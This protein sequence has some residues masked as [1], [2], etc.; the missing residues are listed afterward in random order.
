MSKEPAISFVFDQG[1]SVSPPYLGGAGRSWLLLSW[2]LE[3]DTRWL[4][5]PQLKT[6]SLLN[7]PKAVLQKLAAL[8][9]LNPSAPRN[10]RNFV[11]HTLSPV[12]A[13]AAKESSKPR[14]GNLRTDLVTLQSRVNEWVNWIELKIYMYFWLKDLCYSVNLA[15]PVRYKEIATPSKYN[16]LWDL[17][18]N[19][20]FL[21][22]LIIHDL[23][24]S[25]LRAN[26]SLSMSEPQPVQRSWVDS[27]LFSLLCRYEEGV[28]L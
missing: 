23:T 22:F 24:M 20:Q 17:P 26:W 15:L 12:K 3:F 19:F 4:F 18:G 6:G 27:C 28:H 10:S 25:C 8:S 16:Q 9:D 5:F 13:E 7:Q 1:G 21:F 11:F 2:N 14:V